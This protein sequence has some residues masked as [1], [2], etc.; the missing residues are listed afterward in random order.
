MPILIAIC[1]VSDPRVAVGLS[2]SAG[3]VGA[4]YAPILYAIAQ[5]LAPPQVR[6]V[7]ASVMILFVTGGG[8]LV[9]PWV[10]GALSDA[11]APRFGAHSLRVAMIA[12]LATMTLGV[13]ALLRG[14]RTLS[15]DLRR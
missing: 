1:A 2:V 3:I 6:A 12:V 7:T 8:M 9:G 4:G 5:G 13:I 15:R 14:T 11:L 10:V